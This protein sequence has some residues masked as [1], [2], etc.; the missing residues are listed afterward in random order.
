MSKKIK[1]VVVG[2][3]GYTGAELVRLLLNHPNVEIVDVV[4]ESSAG[5][6]MAEVYTHLT[7]A[8]LPTLK[9]FGEVDF[10]NIDVAFLCLPHGTTQE[11][12]LK[13]PTHVK[14]IDVS[15][16]F[17]LDTPEDYKQWYNHEHAALELQKEAIYGLSEYNRAQIKTKRIIACPGCYPTSILLPLLPL[18]KAG[19]IELEGIIADSK[20]GIS[21]AGRKASQANLFTEIN[22]NVKPYGIAGHRHLGEIEQELA[23]AAGTP[24]MITFTPQ[25]VPLNRGMLSNIYVK[26]KP[27]VTPSDLKNELKSAYVDEPFVKIAEDNYVPVTRDVMTTNLALINVFADRVPNQALIVCTI[28]NLTKG[29]SGQ[30][31]QNMNIAFNLPEST[32][33]QMAPVYP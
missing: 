19:L 24:L 29:A 9:T 2:A 4:G 1:A 27:G 22:E 28:D 13:I 32:G 30:A 5:K 25:V 26:T 10:K 17:R 33:L 7:Y 31:V 12:A 18:V 23:K 16:D 21:G 8:G 14:I 11:I 20:S 6:S 15:A 3:S